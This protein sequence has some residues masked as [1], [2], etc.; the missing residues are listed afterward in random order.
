MKYW[1]QIRSNFTVFSVATIIMLL[2]APAVI[3]ILLAVR[4]YGLENIQVRAL[5]ASAHDG[6]ADMPRGSQER[7]NSRLVCFQTLYGRGP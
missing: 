3:S 5:S 1:I 2:M 7:E 6:C 4:T